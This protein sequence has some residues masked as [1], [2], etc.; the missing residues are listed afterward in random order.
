MGLTPDKFIVNVCLTGAVHTKEANPHIPISTA[1]M[2]R[3]VEECIAQGASIFHV[4][5]RDEDG[6][7][8]WLKEYYQEVLEG[9]RSVSR[10]VILCVSTSGRV[11]NEMEK[12][13]A[14]LDTVPKPDMASLT[15]GSINFVTD[16]VINSPN[17]ISSLALSMRDRGVKPELEIFDIGMARTVSRL[18]ESGV[19]QPPFYANIIL[20]NVASADV[21][22][23]DLAAILR[24]LPQEVIWCL[25]GIGRSQLKANMLGLLFG[26]GVR[27]GLEDNLYLDH[28]KTPATNSALVSRITQIGRMMG[29]SPCTLSETREYLGL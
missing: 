1:E 13:I 22:L 27:V 21:S 18:I 6:E 24:H 29:K 26:M 4:H 23:L 9:I 2:I 5:A 15:T 14:C 12:R 25:G 10:D 11:C 7:S 28:R 20:G 17:L 16:A 3:D 19:L 8:T